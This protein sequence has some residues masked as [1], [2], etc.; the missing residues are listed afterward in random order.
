MKN[1]GGIAKT[2]MKRGVGCGLWGLQSQSGG[3]LLPRWLACPLAFLHPYPSLT[4][5][6]EIT[7]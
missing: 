2:R 7:W 1:Y 4:L 6:A 3:G 5:E